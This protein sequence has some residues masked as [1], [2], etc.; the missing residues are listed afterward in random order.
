MPMT[1]RPR[2]SPGEDATAAHHAPRGS[3]GFMA[4]LV[5]L[6]AF[7]FSGLS[8]YES[9][10]KQ[11]ELEVFVPPMINYARDGETDVFA[12]P[13]TIANSGSNTG[14]VLFLELNVESAKADAEPKSKTFFSAFTGE[15]PRDANAINRAFAPISVPGRAT[16]SDTIRF[17]PQGNALPRIL[18]DEGDYKFTLKVQVARPE[19]PAWLEKLAPLTEPTPLVFTR[20]IP[21]VSQQHLS[22]RRGTISMFAKDWKPATST[23]APVALEKK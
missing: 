21:Y 7:V 10:L 8:Y 4:T 2:I 19:Q 23:S 3:G 22:F 9:S 16:F 14:T 12:I 20:H 15:H 5:S 17:Y 6:L 13:I 1:L 11:A 18:N